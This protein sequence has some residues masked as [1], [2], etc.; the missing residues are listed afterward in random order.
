MEGGDNNAS[1]CVRVALVGGG[2]DLDDVTRDE[3]KKEAE[4]KG[5]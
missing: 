5:A 1:V 4:A 3:H 2:L